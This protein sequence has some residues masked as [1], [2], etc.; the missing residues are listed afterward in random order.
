MDLCLVSYALCPYV[1]R[2]SIALREKGVPYEIK[3]VDL[4]NKPDW[5]LAISPRG[6]VPVLI[7]DGIPLFESAP[8]VEFLDETHPPHLV[9]RDPYD[10]ARRRAW[11]E[12]ANDM[13]SAQY[14]A[15]YPKKEEDLEPAIA[16][17]APVLT[18]YDD[19]LKDGFIADSAFGL[20][21]IAVAPALLRFE[22]VE[23]MTGVKFLDAFPRVRDWSLGIA[24]RP[25]VRES[26]PAD[27][28]DLQKASFERNG[29][30]LVKRLQPRG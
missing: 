18:R 25:S 27:F 8:I 10:R 21:E 20:V 1:H 6:K 30:I 26:A 2:A 11:V 3:F 15:F 14:K 12:V 9:P 24:N 29:S 19:A 23:S 22:I 16:G 4:K 17:L 13:F 5:F 7:A 28:V